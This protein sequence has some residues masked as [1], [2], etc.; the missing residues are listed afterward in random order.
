MKRDID[1][2]RRILLQMENLQGPECPLSVLRSGLNP[3]ADERLRY[4]VQMLIDYGMVEEVDRTPHGLGSVR[5]THEGV[6]FIELCR[7]DRVWRDAVEMVAERTDGLSLV[8]LRAVLTRWAE[9][10]T[11]HDGRVFRHRYQAYIPVAPERRYHDD[12]Y[13]RLSFDDDGTVVSPPPEYRAAPA[14]TP[15]R[16]PTQNSCDYE[17]LGTREGASLPI[18]LV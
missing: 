12:P 8:I 9:E 5:L 16:R 6:E 2:C 3:A 15:R 7:N 13:G 14:R 17:S 18:Y 10:A 1:Y 11:R 4:H